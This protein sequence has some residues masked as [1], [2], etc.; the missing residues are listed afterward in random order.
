MFA[1][2]ATQRH[3]RSAI[4]RPFALEGIR[5][6]VAT[7]PPASPSRRFRMSPM[8]SDGSQIEIGELGADDASAAA[9]LL[10]Q[11][12]YPEAE[13]RVAERL[14]AWAEDRRGTVLGAELDGDLVGLVAVYAFPLFERGGRRGRIV[15]IVV[16]EGRRQLGIGRALL[17]AA[18]QFAA[19]LG[20]G[21]IEVTSAR[22]REA[23]RAFYPRL[24]YEEVSGTSARFLRRIEG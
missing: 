15:A 4:E 9:R 20:C 16:D 22:R 14:A 18:E 24:G 8:G 7:A 11:L 2:A 19:G 21:E 6:P 10:D 1:D 5:A 12:G 23:A 3:P 13:A 17:R